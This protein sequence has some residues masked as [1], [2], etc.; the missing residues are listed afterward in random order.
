MW[1]AAQEMDE[2]MRTP[3]AFGP[4]IVV[5]GPVV[6]VPGG[7]TVSDR[8]LGLLGRDPYWVAG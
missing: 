1:P 3:G 4:G 7:S 8:L 5:F 6:E 2:R